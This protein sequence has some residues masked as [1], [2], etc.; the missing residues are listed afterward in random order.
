MRLYGDYGSSEAFT[1]GVG[2]QS[3]P[4]ILYEALGIGVT[5]VGAKS[6]ACVFVSSLYKVAYRSLSHGGSYWQRSAMGWGHSCHGSSYSS[7][8][9]EKFATHFLAPVS[10]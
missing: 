2:R 7:C 8:R 10:P 9:S 1:R 3:T 4:A 5:L 6:A